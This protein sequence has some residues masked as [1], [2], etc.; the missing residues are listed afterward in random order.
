[1][2]TKIIWKGEL[3]VD[4]SIPVTA[5]GESNCLHSKRQL[6]FIV[7]VYVTQIAKDVK[8]TNRINVTFLK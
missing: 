4:F 7:D 5:T 3:L 8:E 6:R 1:M 2:E